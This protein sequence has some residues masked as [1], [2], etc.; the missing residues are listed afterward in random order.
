MTMQAD[1]TAVRVTHPWVADGQ[2]KIRFAVGG[3]PFADWAERLEFVRMAEDLGFDACWA[4][5]HPTRLADCWTTLAALQTKFSA[6]RLNPRECFTPFAGMP[7]EAIAHY[8]AL[9]DA[10][11]QYFLAVVSRNDVETVRLLAERVIPELRLV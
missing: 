2:G 11:M 4:Y 5:D 1:M 6:I 8:Q 10:G 9:A 3:G 7:D